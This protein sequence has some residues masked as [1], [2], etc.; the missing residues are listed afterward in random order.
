MFGGLAFLL[1]DNM[2]CGVIGKELVVRM[3]PQHCE[4]AL[5][6]PHVRP[7]DFTGRPLKGFVYVG[8]QGIATKRD[9]DAWV[10]KAV[11]FALSLPKKKK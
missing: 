6:R 10:K 8:P 7:M 2:C 11:Q 5:E 4:K 1:H 9:L 3:S